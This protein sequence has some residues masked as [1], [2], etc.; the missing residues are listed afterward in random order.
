M[1]YWALSLRIFLTVSIHIVLT[2]VDLTEVVLV[3]LRVMALWGHKRRVVMILL[4]VWSVTGTA[5]IATLLVGSVQL[6]RK[7][8]CLLIQPSV[9]WASI[10]SVI[11]RRI[12]QC[13]RLQP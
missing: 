5:S 13:L 4:A 1:L 8:R 10:S 12:L 9:Y 6:Y 3:L 2:V 7:L 11:L